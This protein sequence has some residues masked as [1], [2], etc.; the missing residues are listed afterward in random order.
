MKKKITFLIFTVLAVLCVVYS[1]MVLA[2]GSGTSFFLVWIGLAVLFFLFGYSI[3][4][5]F[6]KKVPR[7]V[8]GI[9]IAVVA[10]GFTA[11]FIVEGCIISQMHEKGEAELDYIIVLGAQVRE[12]GPSAAL[13]YRLDEAVE[14]LEDNPK[15]IC[16]VSGGQGANEPYSEAKGMAQYLKEQGIDASRILLEDKS[17]NTEQ[18]MEYSKALI[19]DGASAGI[20]TNDFHLFRAKQIA[21]KYGLDNICGIAAKSTPVYLPNNM[22]REFLAEIKFLM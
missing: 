8:K 12:S 15:T 4:K 21:R 5:S 1:G 19:K 9:C 18:N 2:T 14:Y 20:I 13:K 16:I 17:L 11:F 6:W 22:L 7:L 3:W 10:V